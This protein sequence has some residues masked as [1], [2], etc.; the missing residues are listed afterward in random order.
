V[1]DP[2]DGYPQMPP[3]DAPSWTWQQYWSRRRRYMITRHLALR[4]Q[5]LCTMMAALTIAPSSLSEPPVDNLLL[6]RQDFL[7]PNLVDGPWNHSTHVSKLIS[8]GF[9]IQVDLT[10]RGKAP[11]I[12][13]CK[14]ADERHY[15]QQ[16]INDGILEEGETDFCV[17]HFFLYKPGKLRLIFDGRRLNQACKAPPKFNMKSHETRSRYATRFAWRAADD[18]KNMFFSVK[19]APECRRFF[20]I[21]TELGTYR[22]TSMP[23]GFSW[24]PFIC[25]IA[26][27]EIVKRAQEAGHAV[28]HY[29][30]DFDYYGN[31]PAECLAARDYV[32]KL[33][34]DAG[35]RLNDKKFE[36]PAQHYVSL[37]VE[38]D[39]RQKTSTVP[40]SSLVSLR[41]EHKR[42][43]LDGRP[44]GRKQL[45]SFIGTLVFFNFAHPGFL[46]YLNPLIAFLNSS[47]QDWKRRHDYKS[48]APYMEK[49]LNIV[50][51]MPPTALQ[52]SLTS[53]PHLYTDA[54]NSQLGFISLEYEAAAR[55]EWKKIYRAEA[56]AASWL[57]SQASLPK[58]FVLRIDNEALVHALQKG[59]SKIPEANRACKRLLFLRN[60][61]HII[62]CKHI[63]T[64]LNPADAPSRCSLGPRGFLF[65]R[66]LP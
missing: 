39:L 58:A 38:Y 55:V 35:W 31:T 26:V 27:D 32:L 63:R 48:I 36:P 49:V 17:S 54:T 19:I 57:L 1:E 5:S 25:H 3:T 14:N 53:M 46:S 61:G 56:D 64:E 7:A 16:L 62:K 12:L 23:F 34:K 51:R 41:E 2:D 4:P 20:G 33:F 30:D 21:R 42:L 28:T 43:L 45:A 60:Q 52:V 18:L 40:R 8:T 59:R 6:D 15:I 13:R 37:G 50:E 29:V 24:S 11:P 65:H 66:R 44:I 47:D 9:S 10:K 22:Y